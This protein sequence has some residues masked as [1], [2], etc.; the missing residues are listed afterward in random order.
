MQP[1]RYEIAFQPGGVLDQ[2]PDPAVGE[3]GTVEFVVGPAAEYEIEVAQA[4]HRRLE[5]V[6]VAP[7][8]HRRGGDAAPDLDRRDILVAQRQ[9]V[10]ALRE[11]AAEVVGDVQSLIAVEAA[12]FGEAP[13]LAVRVA[14]AAGGVD[15]G[16]GA[17]RVVAADEPGDPVAEPDGPGMVEIEPVPPPRG[18][19]VP[20]GAAGRSAIP[21]PAPRRMRRRSCRRPGSVR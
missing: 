15:A 11:E 18:R 13:Q 12:G 10:A 16:E 14:D 9:A 8:G 3:Y 19:R 6:P 5:H 17:L 1:C 20:P 7:F 21:A 2:L 4:Q